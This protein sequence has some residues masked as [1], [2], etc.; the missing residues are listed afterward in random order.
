[1]KK[2][3]FVLF[4]LCPH[5]AQADCGWNWARTFYSCD[6]VGLFSSVG[7]TLPVATDTIRFNP[8][9]IPTAPTPAGLEATYSFRT[10]SERKFLLSALK[11]FPYL[12]IALSNWTENTFSTPALQ[13]FLS[14]TY[15]EAY[16]DYERGKGLGYRAGFSL[17]L[18]LGAFLER[19][20]RLSGG[21]SI[22]QGK[23][24]SSQAS[25]YG[26]SLDGRP[27]TFG[28]SLAHEALHPLLPKAES[29]ILSAGLN[30]GGFFAGISRTK[31]AVGPSLKSTIMIYSLRWSGS[32]IALY[33]ALKKETDI[34]NQEVTAKNF[35]FQWKYNSALMLTY[36][37]GLYRG[38]H[39]VG[40]Q[41]YF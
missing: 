32:D 12:G 19:W 21:A 37:Y 17:A 2:F 36:M 11:G 26:I 20:L 41:L 34:S 28:Y 8:A 31:L 18:P 14:T 35:S 39:S 33:G 15:A 9:A 25:S 3:F 29:R 13:K 23:T 38:A 6:T 24:K 22:G 7:R 27:L 40:G 10:D 16:R 5:P 30:L 1:M 4:L